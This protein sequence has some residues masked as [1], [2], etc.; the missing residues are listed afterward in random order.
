MSFDMEQFLI[1]FY[2]ETAAGEP[3]IGFVL[4]AQ[5]LPAVIFFAALIAFRRVGDALLTVVPSVLGF[6][7]MLGVLASLGIPL[8]A[9]VSRLEHD[10]LGRDLELV[11]RDRR[12]PLAQD[13][14][15]LADGARDHRAAPAA[16][17]AAAVGRDGRVA[18]DRAPSGD[19]RQ[20]IR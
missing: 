3:S 17:R 6:A 15:G 10:L 9:G 14:R 11:G 12:D 13:R 19:P 4:A 5:V 2:A 18:L 8:D 20:L 1:T 16:R 7:W